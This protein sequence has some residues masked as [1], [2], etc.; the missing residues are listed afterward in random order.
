VLDGLNDGI[1]FHVRLSFGN[2]SG[3]SVAHRP[4]K[5]TPE[6]KAMNTRCHKMAKRGKFFTIATRGLRPYGSD[7]G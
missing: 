1:S 7:H 3:G 4:K 2:R 6:K 5:G